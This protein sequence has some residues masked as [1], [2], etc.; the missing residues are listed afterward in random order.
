MRLH[1]IEIAGYACGVELH[2]LQDML[3]GLANQAGR[4]AQEIGKCGD[5]DQACNLAHELHHIQFVY[6]KVEDL[7]DVAGQA[8]NPDP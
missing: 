3:V 7:I 2:F 4:I 6:E 5:M 1:R 8:E